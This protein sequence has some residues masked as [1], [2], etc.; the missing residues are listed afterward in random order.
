MRLFASSSACT[1][2]RSSLDFSLTHLLTRP[3]PP[4]RF[5]TH[6]LVDPTHIVLSA[7]QEEIEAAA[8][9]AHAH[10]FITSLPEGYDTKVGERG[11]IS[12]SGGERQRVAIARAVLKQ[13]EVGEGG[14]EFRGKGGGGVRG[15][16]RQGGGRG[17]NK[18]I[19]Y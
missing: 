19:M 12:L 15:E 5:L 3:S 10:D 11:T 9:I 18:T 4:P 7:T 16:A 2:L 8:K 14:G 6:T 13:P 17:G 1:G